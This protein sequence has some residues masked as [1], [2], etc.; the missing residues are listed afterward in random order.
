MGNGNHTKW[1]N[2]R[3]D[4]KTSNDIIMESIKCTNGGKHTY[5]V[6]HTDGTKECTTCGLRTT[7]NQRNDKIR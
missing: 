4:F 1:S 2:E 7:E 6:V 3:R 5:V